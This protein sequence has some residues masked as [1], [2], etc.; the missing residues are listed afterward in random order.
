[1]RV[2]RRWLA[3][4]GGEGLGYEG[5]LPTDRHRGLLW[6]RVAEAEGEGRVQI[7]LVH[8]PRQRRA[9]NH[10]LCQV[11]F[12]RAAPAGEPLLFLVAGTRP[13][14]TGDRLT[15]PPIHA[16]CAEDAV[17]DCPDLADVYSAALVQRASSWGV[18]GLAY[19]PATLKPRPSR[20]RTGLT[21]LPYY[22]P[23]ADLRWILAVREAVTVHGCTP[24][25]LEDLASEPQTAGGR[26]SPDPPPRLRGGWRVPAP[27]HRHRCR[28]PR[29]AGC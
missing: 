10:R 20:H 3:G 25:R 15:S 5:E 7:G 17:R 29:P 23:A 6:E 11:C 26:L 22:A 28:R 21:L 1:M 18:A 13:I 14:T 19:Q 8:G 24:V 27:P 4:L 2:T 9:M 12:A 16:E